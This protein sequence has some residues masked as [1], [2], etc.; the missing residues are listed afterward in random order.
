MSEEPWHD[1]WTGTAGERYRVTMDISA[2]MKLH[3]QEIVETWHR[4]R[5]PRNRTMDEIK[6]W[7]ETNITQRY[8]WDEINATGT[9]GSLWLESHDDLV[10]YQM[11]WEEHL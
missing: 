2:Q 11:V 8:W 7:L 10:Y 9:M 1:D 4:T 5:T 6:A 3:L